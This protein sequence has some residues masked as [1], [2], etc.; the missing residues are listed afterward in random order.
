M[1][2]KHSQRLLC[3]NVAHIVTRNGIAV[4]VDAIFVDELNRYTWF[5]LK[6]SAVG[7]VVTKI[8]I[9]GRLKYIRIHRFLTKCPKNLEVHHIDKNPLNNCLDNLYVVSP[10]NHKFLHQQLSKIMTRHVDKVSVS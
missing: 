3:L 8:R 10:S 6:S 1:K 2:R 4:F 9:D 5:I 7:Y